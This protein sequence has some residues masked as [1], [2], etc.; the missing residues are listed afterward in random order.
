M[1]YFFL[2]LTIAL[3]TDAVSDWIYAKADEI[4]ARAEKLRKEKDNGEFISDN[5]K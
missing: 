4:R 3:I 5:T 2:G 1:F